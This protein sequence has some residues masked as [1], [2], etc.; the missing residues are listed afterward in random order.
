MFDLLP[1][2]ARSLL[3]LRVVFVPLEWAV[4]AWRDQRRSRRG[5]AADVAFFAGQYLLFSGLAIAWL[6]WLSARVD[7]LSG[8]VTFRGE[9]GAWPL[10]IQVVVAVVGGDLLMYWGHR[11]QHAW[12]PLWRFHAVHHTSEDL[13]FVAAHREHPLDGLYTQT[14]MNL[15]AIAL[16]LEIHLVLGLVAFRGLWAILLHANVKLG[17]GIIGDLLGSP[18]LHHWHHALDRHGGNYANLAPYLD[19]LFG[20]YHRPEGDPV[21]IGVEEPHP[22]GYLRLLLW[23]FLPKRRR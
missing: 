18:Q 14:L 8:V 23:P 9:V 10:A 15:P 19:R 17:L 13:D 3:I 11:L 4:P 1:S 7:G 20:T 22:R 6:S 12:G 21:Q 16:G 5:L 2:T